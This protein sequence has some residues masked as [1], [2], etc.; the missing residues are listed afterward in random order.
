MLDIL[1]G[2]ITGVQ[3]T[4]ADAFSKDDNVMLSEDPRYADPHNSTGRYDRPA[5]WPQDDDPVD[6]KTGDLYDVNAFGI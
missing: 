5:D 3:E 2:F 6:D 1:D 4:I